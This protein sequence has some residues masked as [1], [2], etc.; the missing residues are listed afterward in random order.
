ITDHSRS[1]KL[2]G[3]L[4]PVAWLRQAASLLVTN[5]PCRVLHGI[6]V[7][8][9]AD[10]TLDL[11]AGLLTAIDFVIGSV[12]GNWTRSVEEN[13]LRLLRAIESGYIDVIGHPTSAILGKP[14]VPNYVRPAASVDWKSIF[15]HCAKWHV[16][17]ELNCFPSR[18][19]LA[20]PELRKATALGCWI[21][22]GSDAHSRTH[23]S[24]L[25]LGER[26]IK[27]LGRSKILNRLS[28]DELRHWLTEARTIRGTL[29]K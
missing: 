14:G 3:G 2:Q 9:L 20:L 8:I 1:C 15:Q 10:G 19:D 26:I 28:F 4:T 5:L 6:G 29:P 27:H 17:L 12:H 23:L 25:R 11:P 13:T 16:A 7:D 24:H 21:S 22:L 18:L